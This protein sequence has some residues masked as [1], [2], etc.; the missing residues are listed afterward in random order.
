MERAAG[1]WRVVHRALREVPRIAAVWGFL[2]GLVAAAVTP[3][4]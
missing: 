4:G 2:V 3:A 1:P